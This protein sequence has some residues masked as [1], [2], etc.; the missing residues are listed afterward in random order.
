M[1]RQ[2]ARFVCT[3]HRLRKVRVKRSLSV[4]LL[5]TQYCYCVAQGEPA[6]EVSLPGH[7]L[8]RHAAALAVTLSGA[9]AYATVPHRPAGLCRGGDPHALPP[10]TWGMSRC[11]HLLAVDK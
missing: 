7:A 8:R 2:R 4:Q 9:H 1:H 6:Y 10:H 5:K 11:T 3:K